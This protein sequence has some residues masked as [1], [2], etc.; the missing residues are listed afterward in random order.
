M[1]ISG[2]YDWGEFGTR[3]NILPPPLRGTPLI[4]AGG[5]GICET[6]NYTLSFHQEKKQE[7]ERE[8][9]DDEYNGPGA[10]LAGHGTGVP[11]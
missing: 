10:G 5:K 11:A 2:N 7:C 8:I 9:C 4:N 3:Q 6:V 1:P